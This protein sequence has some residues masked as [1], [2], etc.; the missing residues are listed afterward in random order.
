VGAAALASGVA[1]SP[2]NASPGSYEAPQDG[3]AAAS[4]VAQRTQNFRPGLFSVP[5]FEQI[6]EAALS[7]LGW[8]RESNGLWNA[9]FPRQVRSVAFGSDGQWAR[10]RLVDRRCKDPRNP[11]IRLAAFII[12]LDDR[13]WSVD[14]DAPPSIC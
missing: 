1:H 14:L 10:Q 9:A 8:L 2:Q 13:L 5:Q 6:T 3:Q 4:A 7:T 11:S 12:V